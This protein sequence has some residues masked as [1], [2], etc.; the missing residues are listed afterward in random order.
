MRHATS[1]SVSPELVTSLLTE[2]YISTGGVRCTGGVP[3]GSVLVNAFINH[4]DDLE[5][6]FEHPNLP[7]VLEGEVMPRRT[8]RYEA[9]EEE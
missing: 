1:I 6:H 8:P 2:G 9:M 3:P 5:L 7:E 4:F